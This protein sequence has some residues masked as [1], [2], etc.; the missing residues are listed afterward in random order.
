MWWV[1]VDSGMLGICEAVRWLQLLKTTCCGIGLAR[2][3]KTLSWHTH[4][5]TRLT[6]L[7]PGLPGWAGT[8]KAKPNWIL[9]KQETV[10]GSGFSWA[11]QVCTSFQT[12]N[13]TITSPLRFFTGWM[14]FLP[15][16]Q[17]RQST[18][19]KKTDFKL[20]VTEY[21]CRINIFYILFKRVFFAV[22]DI[23]LCCCFTSVYSGIVRF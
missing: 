18:E 6:A 19:G 20:T 16:N 11:M 4:T 13:H 9:L 12:D 22:V 8:R 1:F 3:A 17:Q 7:F 5:H 23:V 21:H 10:S 14:P 15:P 2:Y